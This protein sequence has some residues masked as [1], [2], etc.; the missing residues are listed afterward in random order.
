M[1]RTPRAAG[2]PPSRVRLRGPAR[3]PA[4]APPW[5]PRCSVGASGL[6]SPYEP[7]IDL[8]QE[9]PTWLFGRVRAV[10]LFGSCDVPGK[11][12]PRPTHFLHEVILI[13]LQCRIGRIRQAFRPLECVVACHLTGRYE[14][15]Q[16]QAALIHAELRR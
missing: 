11:I 5:P 1:G 6:P 10:W 9:V 3:R 2:G 4:P 13:L 12:V 16:M 7:S 14:R 15:A 8:H